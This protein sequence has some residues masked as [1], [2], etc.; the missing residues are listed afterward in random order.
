MKH[1]V[2]V[3][4]GAL[5]ELQGLETIDTGFDL[6]RSLHSGESLERLRSKI[7]P[8]TKSSSVNR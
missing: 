5:P 1:P 2:S 4:K 7:L 8:S 3:F 6:F